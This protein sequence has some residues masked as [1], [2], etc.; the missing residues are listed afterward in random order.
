[1]SKLQLTPAE[2]EHLE[3]SRGLSIDVNGDERLRGLNLAESIEYL[4]LRK[5]QGPRD[6]KTMLRFLE[7]HKQYDLARKS[8]IAPEVEARNAGAKH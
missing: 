6:S 8:V 4:D 7:L 3:W 1:M 5:R 2:R